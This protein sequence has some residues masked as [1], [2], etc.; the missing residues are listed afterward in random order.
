[1]ALFRPSNF[2]S[3]TFQELV[4]TKKANPIATLS[5]SV[6]MLRHLGLD[7]HANVINYAIDRTVNYDKIHTPGTTRFGEQF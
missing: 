1:V 7:Y 2:L 3:L 4:G 5:A 6:Q